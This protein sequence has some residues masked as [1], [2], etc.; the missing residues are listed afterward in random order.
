[1]KNICAIVIHNETRGNLGHVAA[2]ASA[3][4]QVN[5]RTVLV[6]ANANANWLVDRETVGSFSEC[7]QLAKKE[8][9][10]RLILMTD[11]MMGPVYPLTDLLERSD[12]CG[13]NIWTLVRKT[14]VF[15]FSEGEWATIENAASF[16]EI[17]NRLSDSAIPEL[18]PTDDLME[19][20]AVP[21]LDE[22][23]M[24]VRDRKC[25]FFMHE[26]F[27]RNYSDVITTTLGH[28]GQVFY[29]WLLKKSGWDT[30]LL[31]DYLLVN[32]H[33]QDYFENMHL[34]YVLPSK[35]ADRIGTDEHIQTY[36]LALVMHLYYPDKL[37]ESC[38][39][40]ARFPE[41][42]HVIITTSDE[43][44]REKIQCAFAKMKFASLDVRVIENRGRDVSS[45]LVGAAEVFDEYEYVCFFHDKKT[46]QTKPGSIGAGFA[47][48][49]QENLFATADYVC[50]MIKLFRDNPRL[51]MISPPP[52]H[53]GDYFF[54]LGL[55]WGPNYAGTKQLA[56]KLGFQA[57][58]AENRMPITALGTCF[59]FRGKALKPLSDHHWRYDEFPPEPNN[60]DGTILHAIERIYAFACVEAGYYPAFAVSDRYASVEYSSM[61]YYVREYNKVCIKH[62]MLS[63][64]RNMCWELEARLK[65]R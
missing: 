18:Y 52:P 63:Y 37:E 60:A 26:V 57:P 10:D 16:E 17:Q 51:G 45:L 32:C 14:P 13:K 27:H 28:Q 46:L 50:N 4:D 8:Q 9:A 11:E 29:N 21:M 55:D 33:Q 6:T 36:K 53:H 40:A 35:G 39:F 2:I 56:E 42:T 62:G 49:L 25:P 48:R 12:R 59:W 41:H 47:H 43:I 19:V 58:I 23:L 20:T 22:P 31:W 1:M 15:G 24:L 34:S 54:T 5:V 3:W 61:R 65:N 38:S 64:H 44:K 30:N 7:V